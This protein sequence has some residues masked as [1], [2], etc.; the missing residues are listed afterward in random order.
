MG[1]KEKVIKQ[2]NN[3]FYKVYNDT[4]DA[5]MKTIIIEEDKIHEI[6]TLQERKSEKR[7]GLIKAINTDMAEYNDHQ[8]LNLC[9]NIDIT[10]L[11]NFVEY[12]VNARIKYS[13]N[14]SDK[15]PV[16][17]SESVP[18]SKNIT[19]EPL[20]NDDI[21]EMK[22]ASIIE[23]GEFDIFIHYID[24]NCD[25]MIPTGVPISYLMLA[26]RKKL[27]KIARGEKYYYETVRKFGS[28]HYDKVA[29]AI[30]SRR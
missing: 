4:E 28:Y 10:N 14:V 25:G 12:V 8:G 24:D 20:S 26:L 7:D 5:Y 22:Q 19:I 17:H 23:A 15:Q 11:E 13:K 9:E 29:R 30:D 6:E 16:I 18:M 27:I 2:L 3:E 1:K 21:E